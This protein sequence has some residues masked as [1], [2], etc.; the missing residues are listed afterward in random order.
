MYTANVRFEVIRFMK[1]VLERY[2]RRLR[3]FKTN[4][5]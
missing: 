1:A 4:Y 2:R 5:M 3:Q